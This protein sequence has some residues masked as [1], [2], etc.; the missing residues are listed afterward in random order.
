M[1]LEIN[2]LSELYLPQLLTHWYQ[3]GSKTDKMNHSNYRVRHSVSYF[4]KNR[5]HIDH[6]I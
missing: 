1:A 5:R 2:A 3:Y 6:M 4:M